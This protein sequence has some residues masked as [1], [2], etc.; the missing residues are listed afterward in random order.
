[1]KISRACTAAAL[2]A[3]LALTACG[4]T[5]P[6]DAD[7]TAGTPVS[8]APAGDPTDAAAPDDAAD[9]APDDGT[10]DAKAPSGVDLDALPL[11]A[12]LDRTRPVDEQVEYALCGVSL[13]TPAAPA[14]HRALRGLPTWGGE[15]DV[16]REV[17]VYDDE[18]TAERVLADALDEACDSAE[19]EDGSTRHGWADRID[20]MYDGVRVLQWGDGGIVT[21]ELARFGTVVVIS[22]QVNSG[23]TTER[24]A[25][26]ISEFDL[27]AAQPLF[28]AALELP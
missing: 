24:D 19:L 22:S 27:T 18:A 17:L 23:G 5:D 7:G 12:G 28:D 2:T 26:G 9:D 8:S 6:G 15:G 21:T 10:T 25:Q 3:V 14:S 13:W 1:M 16:F 11:D 20:G 4:E